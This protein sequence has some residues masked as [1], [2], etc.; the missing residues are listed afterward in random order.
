MR[1]ILVN[2]SYQLLNK[3]VTA[4]TTFLLTVIIVRLYGGEAFGNYSVIINYVMFFYLLSDFGF[5]P[6]IVREF[7][8]SKEYAKTNFLKILLFRTLF[9]IFIVAFAYVLLRFLPYSLD[10]KSIIVLGL[11]LIPIQSIS[12][13]CTY[14]FQSYYKYYGMLIANFVGS[15]VLIVGIYIISVNVNANIL[16]SIMYIS[17]FSAIV[18]SLA[19]LY[20]TKEFFIITSNIFDIGLFKK[21]LNESYIYGFTLLIN[22]LMV[23]ADRLILSAYRP[24]LEVGYYSLSYKLFDLILVIPTFL[25]NASYPMLVSYYDKDKLQF[26]NL[27]KK[28]ILVLS[29]IA[30]FINIMLLLFG[31]L[32]ILVVWGEEMLNGY[33]LLL[34]LSF[35][36][37]VFFLTAPLSSLY[38][39]IRQRAKLLYT[40]LAGA[41]VNITLCFILIPTYGSIAA[42]YLTGITEALVL[43]LLL[44]PI[45]TRG[46]LK[47]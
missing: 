32:L 40:Y 25:L 31:R 27:Y 36:I 2:T 34:I 17:I 43:L 45:Y 21:L 42:A 1:K 7:T 19:S 20:L 37:L 16:I 6:Y 33:P 15:L 29:L 8:E 23:H 35:S 44:V 41:A 46:Y 9:S 10:V 24:A 22:A 5:L 30:V 47:E 26:I 3:I 39:I 11:L 18:V 28:I 14:I 13:S 38:I 12:S 4:L